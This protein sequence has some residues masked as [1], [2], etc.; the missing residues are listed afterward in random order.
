MLKNIPKIII[1]FLLG[2]LGGVFADQILWPYFIE[3]PLFY[4]YRLEQAPVFV[5]ETNEI[6]IQENTALQDAI[7]KVEKAVVG[8]TAKIKGGEVLAGSGLVITS[9]GLII[10]LA[11]LVPQDGN[12]AFFVNNK[13]PTFQV[14]KR[15][16]KENLALVKVEESNLPT[17]GFADSGSLRFG[18]RVF[19]IGA[20]LGNGGL[21]KIVN[22]GIIKTYNTKSILTDISEEENLKGSPLFNIKGELVGLTTID[23]QGK[24]SAIPIQ[25]IRQFIGF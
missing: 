18:Q 9:D 15:D 24:V 1:V 21:Q 13:A 8:I 5:T 6:I 3:R 4:E 25:K 12:F 20:V 16:L 10:T 14:L 11:E 7:G 19:L 17:V 22:E 2:T 23:A